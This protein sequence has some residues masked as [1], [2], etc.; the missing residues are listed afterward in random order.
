[1]KFLLERLFGKPV[2]YRLKETGDI[3]TWRQETTRLLRAI[4]LSIK[5]TVQI[6]DDQW[7]EDVA[8]IIADGI[9]DI[10]RAEYIDTLLSDLAATLAQVVF[11]QIGNMPVPYSHD[12]VPLTAR[13]WTLDG[14]RSVQYVQTV[15][16]RAAVQR[17]QRR[18]AENAK[19]AESEAKQ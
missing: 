3:R 16:Q 6:A 8:T 12:I 11:A 5:S 4:D 10:E 14:F 1:M 17:Q 7:R 19:R 18:L 9:R 2:W 15:A 13:N